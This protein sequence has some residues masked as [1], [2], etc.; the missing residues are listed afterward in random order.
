MSGPGLM[1]TLTSTGAVSAGTPATL[2][3]LANGVE[4]KNLI[5]V[6]LNKATSTCT[7]LRSP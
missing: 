4:P 6:G 2:G 7:L 3:N 1:S 5:S